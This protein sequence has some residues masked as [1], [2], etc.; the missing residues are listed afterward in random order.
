M[1]TGRFFPME[2]EIASKVVLEGA[3][4]T[5]A[6]VYLIRDDGTRERLSSVNGIAST[7]EVDGRWIADTFK[8]AFGYSPVR[9]TRYA[10]VD[11]LVQAAY[12]R[13][14]KVARATIRSGLLDSGAAVCGRP[15]QGEDLSTMKTLIVRVSI[16]TERRSRVRQNITCLQ[17]GPS[18][19]IHTIINS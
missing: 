18:R 14:G 17:V 13:T 10:D 7:G 8:A 6:V 11:G 9:V 19:L 2:F 15:H 3:V 5:V 12:K 4:T 16:F 1:K